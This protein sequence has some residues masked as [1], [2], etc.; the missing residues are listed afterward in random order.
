MERIGAFFSGTSH[1][2]LRLENLTLYE[3]GII[4]DR[5]ENEKFT[6]DQYFNMFCI[7]QSFLKTL[8]KMMMQE[9]VLRQYRDIVFDELTKIEDD[10]H[11]ENVCEYMLTRVMGVHKTDKE[12]I[13]RFAFNDVSFF[14]SL[15]NKCKMVDDTIS[16]VDPNIFDILKELKG[17]CESL[18][19]NVISL[20]YKEN[21]IPFEKQ[22]KLFIVK[23]M[24]LK[25]DALP[26]RCVELYRTKESQRKKKTE[27]A[28]K[29]I[30][31]AFTV[32]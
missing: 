27:D 6:T 18:T 29:N 4:S 3:I 30:K 20:F 26:Y 8:L 32:Q 13:E 22:N 14:D 17:E 19:N 1:N 31:P 15:S 24:I 21:G 16:K 11:R 7:L 23:E 5:L 28:Y 12:S 25:I 2:Q 10:F 9:E